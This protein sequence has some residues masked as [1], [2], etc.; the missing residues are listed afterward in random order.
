MSLATT[1]TYSTWVQFK[2]NTNVAAQATIP[3]ATWKKY[4]IRAERIL[5]S[6]V[7]IKE[8]QKYDV[9][10]NLK[11]PIKDDDNLSWLPDE[12]ALAHIEITSDLALKGDNIAYDGSISTGEQ[13]SGS[14]Y[15]IN[16]QKKSTSSSDDV[17][18]E[19][20]PYAKRLLLP[21]TGRTASAKY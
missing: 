21:W 14:G 19:I 15:S 16:K 6:Y 4:A 5:D 11:F 2:D 3:E 20:P 10:Q 7:N 12:V 13:W 1:P 9:D 17:K 8:E 18:I